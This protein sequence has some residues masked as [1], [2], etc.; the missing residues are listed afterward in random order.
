[1]L[2]VQKAMWFY[3]KKTNAHID[4][5]TAYLK[6]YSCLFMRLFAFFPL[7]D[8][9]ERSK[10]K[11]EK[12]WFCMSFIISYSNPTPAPSFICILFTHFNQQFNFK[13]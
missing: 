9:L 2:K 10:Q 3:F 13:Q 7:F 5:L 1:M 12:S 8:V 11:I 4:C 6:F